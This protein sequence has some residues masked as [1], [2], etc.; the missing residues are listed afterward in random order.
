MVLFLLNSSYCRAVLTI[1][2]VLFLLQVLRWSY[3]FIIL[4]SEVVLLW[5]YP[6]Y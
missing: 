1:E 5:S 4:I 2:L 3:L 6:Y